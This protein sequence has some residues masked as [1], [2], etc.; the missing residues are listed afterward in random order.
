MAL[1]L[2]GL[3]VI[4]LTLYLA[5][6]WRGPPG[7]PPARA[8]APGPGAPRLPAVIILGA[9]ALILAA[10]F[11]LADGAAYQHSFYSPTTPAYAGITSES[12]FVP[13]SSPGQPTPGM[14]DSDLSSS[15]CWNEWKPTRM[16]PP[17]IWHAGIRPPGSHLGS[18][19][20]APACWPRPQGR[21]TG[22]AQQC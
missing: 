5:F 18:S 10:V 11:L 7:F 6:W 9:A 2:A 3:A 19:A 20:T 17:R 8:A 14:R 1:Q 22:P 16:P 21:F 13:G 12:P 4:G 15:A